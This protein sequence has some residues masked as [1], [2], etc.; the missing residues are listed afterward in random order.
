[1]T[2]STGRADPADPRVPALCSPDALELPGLPGAAALTV[3]V[4]TTHG[5]KVAALSGELDGASAPQL[6]GLLHLLGTDGPTRLV[7]D[8]SRLYFVDPTSLRVLREARGRFA[9][10]G[11]E[12]SLAAVRPRVARILAHAGLDRVFPVFRTVEDAMVL[13]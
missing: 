4:A 8:L 9:A 6:A 12:L 10:D 1:M 13:V 11:G 3:T 2:D 5:T 7:L